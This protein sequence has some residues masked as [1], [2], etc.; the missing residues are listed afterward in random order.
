MV[1]FQFSVLR[2]VGFVFGL[3]VCIK[4][5]FLRCFCCWFKKQIL[6]ISEEKELIGRFLRS[7]VLGLIELI[8][9]KQRIEGLGM[10]VVYQ[11]QKGFIGYRQ[12]SL[13][14]RDLVKVGYK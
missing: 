4:K 14:I 8:D 3:E 11:D 1:G 6:R 13:G 10:L 2:L 12:R 9:S 5:I 7:L